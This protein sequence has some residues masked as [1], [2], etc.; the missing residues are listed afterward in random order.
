MVFSLWMRERERERERERG[1]GGGGDEGDRQTETR[2]TVSVLIVE[3]MFRRPKHICDMLT[4]THQNK[5]YT[6]DIGNKNTSQQV[7]VRDI[8]WIGFFFF[9]LFFLLF[10]DNPQE[11]N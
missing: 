2:C 5:F 4:C 11:S 1:G 10:N 9:S 7:P 6:E 8:I 3:M